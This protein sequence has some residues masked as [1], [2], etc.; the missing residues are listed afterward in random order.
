MTLLELAGQLAMLANVA[1][2]STPVHVQLSIGPD[3][4]DRS[5]FC[6][7]IT[8]EPQWSEGPKPKI[9]SVVLHVNV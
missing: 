1:D 9:D 8:A 2:R 4:L 6:N 7:V 3:P 5:T